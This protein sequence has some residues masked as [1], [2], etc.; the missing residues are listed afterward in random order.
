MGF[1]IEKIR[2]DFPI[3]QQ[4]VYKKPLVYLDNGATTHKPRV[5]IETLRELQEIHNSSISM[6]HPPV[7]SSLPAVRLA[8]STR[9][10]FQWEKSM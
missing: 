4:Q 2:S 8:P 10:H 5:V 9:L 7:R 6:H 1:N 3:L